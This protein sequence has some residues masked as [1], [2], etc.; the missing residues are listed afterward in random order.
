MQ[1]LRYVL[2]EWQHDKQEVEG[3]PRSKDLKLS[4]VSKISLIA[5]LSSSPS[6]LV[7]EE[8]APKIFQ[9]LAS[10]DGRIL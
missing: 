6:S 2:S 5:D 3:A 7:K 10:S 8:D 1:H 4:F 9:V